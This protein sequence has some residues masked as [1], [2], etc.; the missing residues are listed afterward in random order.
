MQVTVLCG[1]PSAEREISLIS[2]A[3]VA[4]ALKSVGH[5]VFTADVSPDDLSALDHPA[6]R[7]RFPGTV[8]E[9]HRAAAPGRGASAEERDEVPDRGAA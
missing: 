2:G 4:E 3:A 6:A 1:G 7:H 9:H 5:E 8:D